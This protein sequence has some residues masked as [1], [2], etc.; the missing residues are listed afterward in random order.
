MVLADTEALATLPPRELRAGY[1]EIA[2]AGLIGDAAFFD[3]CETHGAAVVAGNREA[4]A[5][6]EA[7][8][9]FAKVSPYP[10]P[11]TIFED[12]YWEVDNKTEAGA[13]G[14]HFFND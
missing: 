4:Q 13:T 5:E 11:E 6:A 8:A 3:W 7:S 10:E 12:V 1:A 9:E 14:R 2:K